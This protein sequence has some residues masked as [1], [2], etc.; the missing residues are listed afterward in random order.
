M[1][2]KKFEGGAGVAS[3][4]VNSSANAATISVPIFQQDRL[5]AR[6]K[7]FA[8]TPQFHF[9]DRDGR[10][11]AYLRKKPF[12]WKDEIRVFTDETRSLELLNIKARKIVDWGSAFDVTDSINHQKVGTLKRRGWRSLLRSEWLIADA[13]EQEIGRIVESSAVM[14]VMRRLISNLL[15]QTYIFEVHGQ[16]VGMAK[17][18]FSFF[19]PRMEADFSA[20]SDRMLDRRLA[21]AAIVLLMSVEGRQLA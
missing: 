11:L 1:I 7:I 16:P 6:Q 5:T 19:V 4:T 9:C 18:K 10:T 17:Q 13:T 20:D 3:P 12:S 15:S 2:G 14:A 21:T 8:L